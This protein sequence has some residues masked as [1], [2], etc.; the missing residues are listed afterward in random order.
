MRFVPHFLTIL[1]LGGLL[2][3]CFS[4]Q[5]STWQRVLERGVLRVGT[6]A[7]YPP[8]EY[9]DAEG[10]IVGFDAD[11]LKAVGQRLGVQVELVNISY[12]GLYDS[13]IT[14]QV[15]LL[16]SA[17]IPMPQMEEKVSYSVPYFN[18]GQHLVVRV[19]S[20]VRTMRDMEG[21]RLAVEY[22]SDGDAEAR[23]WQRRLAALTVIRYA[24]PDAA[25]QA[26]IEGEADAALVDGISAR[27]GVGQ[28]PE[29][30]AA[31]AA[32]DVLFVLVVSEDSP[33]LLSKVNEA[34]HEMLRDGTV[35][36]LIEKWFG[37][38]R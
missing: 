9:V 10:Q 6:D 25:L 33:I 23:R 12:D 14:A 26:V 11:L 5:D 1:T 30:A 13:L 18:A 27:L 16:A 34:L 22:G 36:A 24:D 29:L 7:S 38:Q 35:E 4:P 21:R 20:S 3:A 32:S 28:H 17:L 2:N 37:P 15:D 19:G 31:S 8:F